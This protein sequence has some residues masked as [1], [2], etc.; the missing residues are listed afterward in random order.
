MARLCPGILVLTLALAGSAS[1]SQVDEERSRES[2]RFRLFNACEPMSLV[3]IVFDQGLRE[4]VE[5]MA[6]SRLRAARLYDTDADRSAVSSL[7]V[8]EIFGVVAEAEVVLL[9]YHK[10]VRG[11]F[12][13][14]WFLAKTWDVN[15]MY[16]DSVQGLSELLDRFVL[17]YLRVN[18]A[19]CMA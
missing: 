19:A 12:S 17:E 4:R 7:L 1:G 8:I 14:R 11:S 5:T 18:E 13:E 15:G 9:S 3:A 6:E 2:E 10:P 16:R